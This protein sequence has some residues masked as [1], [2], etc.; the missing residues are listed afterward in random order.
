MCKPEFKSELTFNINDY[1]NKKLEL[2]QARAKDLYNL[3]L[4]MLK[5]KSIQE[6]LEDKSN[7]DAFYNEYNNLL[8]S[9]RKKFSDEDIDEIQYYFRDITFNE[10]YNEYIFSG[11]CG[12][13][14]ILSIEDYH[15][16]TKLFSLS[17]ADIISE[18]EYDKIIILLR[19]Y[20]TKKNKIKY[21]KLNND[22]MFV[23]K[24]A[25]KNIELQKK[26]K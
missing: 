11:T 8:I 9:L 16:L 15:I 18:N 4:V 24:Y 22:I 1:L 13:I 2:K 23:N 5:D 20:T 26:E 21:F 17:D 3:C 6:L 7:Y 19:H 12:E 10:Y 14:R 25:S